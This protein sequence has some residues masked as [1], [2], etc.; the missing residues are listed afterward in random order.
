MIFLRSEGSLLHNT[1]ILRR[2]WGPILLRK[3]QKNNAHGKSDMD[4]VGM[5]ATTDIQLCL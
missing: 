1:E 4:S 3:A 5:G 2:L